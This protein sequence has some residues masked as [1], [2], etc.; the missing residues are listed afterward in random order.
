MGCDWWR[1]V[2]GYSPLIGQVQLQLGGAAGGA[3]DQPPALAAGQH[4][5]HLAVPGMTNTQTLLQ[6]S[7]IAS[8]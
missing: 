4:L 7:F 6:F 3:G 1:A 2:T 5:L 8:P